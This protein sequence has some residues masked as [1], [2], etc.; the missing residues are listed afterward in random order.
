MGSSKYKVVG[1]AVDG[2][3]DDWEYLGYLTGE[4]DPTNAF[5]FCR[6]GRIE[7]LKSLFPSVSVAYNFMLSVFLNTKCPIQLYLYP[8]I[9]D[10]DVACG[11][12]K[13]NYISTLYRKVEIK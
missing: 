2:V 9:E 6:F 11:L 7:P 4:S 3:L 5:P 8:I 13:Q 12:V 1:Y 10:V